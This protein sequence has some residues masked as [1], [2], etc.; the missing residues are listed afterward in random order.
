MNYG[1]MI[2]TVQSGKLVGAVGT[3]FTFYEIDMDPS[4]DLLIAAGEASSGGTYMDLAIMEQSQSYARE[5][6][7]DWQQSLITKKLLRRLSPWKDAPAEGVSFSSAWYLG[8]FFGICPTKLW[9]PV[10][11][12]TLFRFG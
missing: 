7:V 1:P 3:A 11:L 8:Q 10:M 12:V 5:L 2:E 4:S 9:T 6:N